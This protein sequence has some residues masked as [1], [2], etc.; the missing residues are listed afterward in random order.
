MYDTAL[1]KAKQLEICRPALDNCTDLSLEWMRKA[2][3]ALETCQTQFDTD[4]K[5]ITDLTGQVGDLETQLTTTQL[6]LHRNRTAAGV[7]WAITGGI[8]A[9]TVTTAIVAASLD[10]P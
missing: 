2:D 7:A 5:L 3:N 8:I 10:A 1:T 6:K 9:G 4:E